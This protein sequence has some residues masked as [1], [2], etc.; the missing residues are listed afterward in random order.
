M[1]PS[2]AATSPKYMH[3]TTA[4][5]S[6]HAHGNRIHP[7][8]HYLLLTRRNNLPSI[9]HISLDHNDIHKWV[10]WGRHPV[11]WFEGGEF[12]AKNLPHF[13]AMLTLMKEGPQWPLLTS[14]TMNNNPIDVDVNI[15]L[16]P[17][18]Y[19]PSLRTLKIANCM[20]KGVLEEG[21]LWAVRKELFG[22]SE[23]GFQQLS[24][25][26]MSENDVVGVDLP[27]VVELSHLR[28]V[29][30]RG[31]RLEFLA[32]PPRSIS[33]AMR[34]VRGW[35]EGSIIMIGPSKQIPLAPYIGIPHAF[36]G[37][38]VQDYSHNPSLVI[39]GLVSMNELDPSLLPFLH[40]ASAPPPTNHAQQY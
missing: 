27:D 8:F 17:F 12:V 24:V 33:P 16:L 21:G 15:M 10:E 23:L 19:A 40:A 39:E 32:M 3:L 25:L 20:L 26:D 9:R 34:H 38:A 18:S 37:A 2:L 11:D 4:S 6:F 14:F 30:L 5:P 35:K 1:A 29:S 22:E 7:S 36:A 31:N 13:F 28:E